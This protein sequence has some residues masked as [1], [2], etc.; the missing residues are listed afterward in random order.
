M[1][2]A[3]SEEEKRRYEDN[4]N[5][6]ITKLGDND[7]TDDN[8]KLIITANMFPTDNIVLPA[9][10]ESY[11]YRNHDCSLGVVVRDKI[12]KV[13]GIDKYNLEQFSTLKK[14]S[15]KYMPY[16]S[17]YV[18]VVYGALNALYPDFYDTNYIIIDS[19]KKAAINNQFASIATEIVTV[20]DSIKLSDEAVILINSMKIN[21]LKEKYPQLNNMKVITYTGD[22][23]RAL[24]MYLVSVGI[25]PEKLTLDFMV[26]SDT[27][28]KLYSFVRN[29]C[30]T[31]NISN[32]K[33]ENLDMYKEDKI[34]T[35]KLQQIYD[36]SFYKFLLEAVNVSGESFNE[37]HKRLC[38]GDTF[39]ADNLIILDGIIESIGS[40]KLEE[41]VNKYNSIIDKKIIE[42]SYKTN[43]EIIKLG[44]I[45]I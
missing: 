37:L 13:D 29:F 20:K 5:V 41:I 27:S 42:N 10:K 14:Q 40:E 30:K 6:L 33:Y 31:N 26:E 39:D 28:S 21:E 11:V 45:E 25:I 43:E 7:Y 16:N 9:A 18:S 44:K 36:S 17:K 12:K 22:A 1:I 3:N 15:E 19:Y 24:D 2:N 38:E 23:N 4:L 32:L 8:I 35:Q 34:N